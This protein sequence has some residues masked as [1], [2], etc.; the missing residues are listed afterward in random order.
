MGN[1]KQR[2]IQIFWPMFRACFKVKAKELNWEIQKESCSHLKSKPG[3]GLA[4]LWERDTL[5]TI[6]YAQQ[7]VRLYKKDA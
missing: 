2:R 3:E 5:M 1:T 4:K 6:V 7:G